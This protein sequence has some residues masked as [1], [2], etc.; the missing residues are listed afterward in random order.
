MVIGRKLRRFRDVR[1]RSRDGRARSNT[2]GYVGCQPYSSTT[3]YAG[4]TVNWAPDPTKTG[5]A[6][7]F[8]IYE[9]QWNGLSLVDGAACCWE[10][11]LG[12]NGAPDLTNTAA[13]A[14]AKKMCGDKSDG[15]TLA[16]ANPAGQ[17]PPTPTQCPTE[18]TSRVQCITCCEAQ[19]DLVSKKFTDDQAKADV[20]DYLQRCETAC[21]DAALTGGPQPTITTASL[22]PLV[23][24]AD[25][26]GP[27]DETATR[28]LASGLASNAALAQARA[29]CGL[30]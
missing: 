17:K 18:S 7:A 1:E 21:N 4:H 24:P 23:K 12:S 27:V 15:P 13:S 26:N 22:A 16:T 19:A 6:N 30:Q 11:P 2:N 28:C 29:L 3:T 9:P 25:F 14:C 5:N 8:C 10:G 20:A